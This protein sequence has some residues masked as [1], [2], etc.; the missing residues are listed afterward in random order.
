MFTPH[1]RKY[2]K[3]G[4]VRFAAK[5]LQNTLVFL[6]RYAVLINDFRSN[7]RFCHLS[8][9]AHEARHHKFKRSHLRIGLGVF[10]KR[11]KRKIVSQKTGCKTG[12]SFN[13]DFITSLSHHLP[14]RHPSDRM[15]LVGFFNYNAATFFILIAAGTS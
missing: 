15:V 1:N 11:T 8:H 10:D 14:S 13:E 2:S 7:L 9:Y 6:W 12:L 3:F 4:E 5:Y